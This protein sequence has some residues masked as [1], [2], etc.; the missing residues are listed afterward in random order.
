M[1]EETKNTDEEEGDVIQQRAVSNN[2]VDFY[3]FESS[4]ISHITDKKHPVVQWLKKKC[5]R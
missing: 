4:F 3:V 2:P 5:K 1:D